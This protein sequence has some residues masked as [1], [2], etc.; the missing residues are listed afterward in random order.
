LAASAHGIRTD[1]VVA[2][3]PQLVPHWGSVSGTIPLGSQSPATNPA[4]SPPQRYLY[5][6]LD[7]TC[8]IVPAFFETTCDVST[9]KSARRRPGRPAQ[10]P[11]GFFGALLAGL[12]K[13][14]PAPPPF[15]ESSEAS[16]LEGVIEPG[17]AAV[18]TTGLLL[19]RSGA[20]ISIGASEYSITPDSSITNR[21]R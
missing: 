7:N 3:V 21:G 11:P 18:V 19:L 16:H 9:T 17:C 12:R 14:T 6:R 4:P 1:N 20:L 2:I 8:Q 13:R 10:A 15:P 5:S